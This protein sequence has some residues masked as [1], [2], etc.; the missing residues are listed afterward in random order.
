MFYFPNIL[1]TI[2]NGM[3]IIVTN[4]DRNHSEINL[5]YVKHDIGTLIKS[6]YAVK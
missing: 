2:N 3:L 6:V 4:F 1:W 5:N